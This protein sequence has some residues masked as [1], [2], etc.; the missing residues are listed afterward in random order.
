MKTTKRILSAVLCVLMLA[1][2]FPLTSFAAYEN[3]HTNTGNQI[4]DLIAVAMTQ[5]GY[6]EGNSTSQHGGTS[7]GSGNYTKYGAWYGI[8]PGAWCAM[9]VSWCANQAGISSSIIPKHSSCDIGMQWF[10]NNGR[11]QWSKCLG[12]TYTPKRGDIIY[13]RTNTSITYDSTHVGIITNADA[14]TIY[15]IEGNASNKC[16]EK[17]YSTSS[18]YILG[19]GTPA[20][21]GGS[22]AAYA[23]GTYKVTATSLNMRS[24]AG[25]EGSIVQVLSNGAQV[26]V[27]AVAN[28]KWGYC[29][30]NGK[31]GWVSLAYCALVAET[32]YYTI[33]ME[34]NGGTLTSGQST[35]SI[36]KGTK[37]STV[38]GSMPQA[39]RNGYDFGGWYCAAFNYTLNI[40]D[41]YGEESNS[42]FEAVWTAKLGNYTIT[43]N[44]DPLNIR[45]GAGSASSVIG[46]VP[47]GTVVNITTIYG[48]WGYITYNGV[49]GW[50]SLA[51][52]TYHSAYVAPSDPPATQTYTLTFDPNGGTMPSGVSLT[53]KFE[54]EEKFVD[55]IG[56]FPIPTHPDSNM[57]FYGWRWSKAGEDT[58]DF[59]WTD[60]WGSQ[61]YYE[62]FGDATFIADWKTHSHSYSSTVTKA[63]TCTSTGVRTYICESCGHSYTESIAKTSHSYSSAVTTQPTCTNAGVRTYT[64]AYC[65]GSY[66]ES[67]AKIEHIYDFVGQDV[68]CIYC[69]DG[70]G[71]FFTKNGAQYFC[72]N[73]MVQKGV[74]YIEGSFYY[75]DSNGILAK[76]T[77]VNVKESEKNGY[78]SD[79][80]DSFY[81]FDADGKLTVTGFV[82]LNGVTRYYNN[83]VLTTG[84][85]RIGTDYYYFDSNG[86][87]AV[88]ANRTVGSNSY[89]IPEGSYYFLADGKMYLEALADF[90]VIEEDGEF[91]LYTDGEIAQAGM[92]YNGT[93]YYYVKSDGRL[94]CD[95]TI[96]T[97]Y[98]ETLPK[99]YYR[100]EADCKMMKDGWLTVS[101][102]EYGARKFF[103]I[104]GRHASGLTKIG[105]DYY[106]FNINNGEMASGDDVWVPV[107]SYGV[108]VGVHSLGSD[109]KM[110]NTASAA[111]ASHFEADG[112]DTVSLSF[113]EENNDAMAL[114]AVVPTVTETV[115]SNEDDN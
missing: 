88:N 26:T 25:T 47:K 46:Q 109:G 15:T 11:W 82:T 59:R 89:G 48:D 81:S 56:V 53:Y 54:A 86:N 51:Y 24:T 13:F 41:T 2:A 44:S 19:Y 60:G 12:G 27:T 77:V 43:T 45:D 107:N 30:Y 100:F 79:C 75:A 104:N 73:G 68:K 99:A 72:M 49:S 58:N 7:G 101:T 9:F 38:M 113:A 108:S 34:P 40:N 98:S 29:E 64:C 18:A 95:E 93:D 94:A 5:R 22:V 110:V 50:V 6:T 76:N 62:S 37:Y 57:E 14:S 1:G 97:Y 96:Y 52:C 35:Y 66:T 16:Q 23:P 28:T 80:G 36:T 114:N 115:S 55:V 83:T 32:T 42:T 8:N 106:F 65:G 78:L 70:Y 21:T 92:Y 85:T 3:T 4:E 17:S 91:Y 20:Y 103:F 112:V 69:D 63:A 105:N 39:K 87:M 111:R 10:Q 33:T 90:S 31:S 84:F 71:G 102:E 67:I 61:P 74:I